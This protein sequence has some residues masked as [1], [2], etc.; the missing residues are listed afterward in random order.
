MSPCAR[1]FET[2]L[3]RKI[4]PNDVLV[5]HNAAGNPIENEVV[6]VDENEIQVA[7]LYNSGRGIRTVKTHKYDNLWTDI[8]PKELRTDKPIDKDV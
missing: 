2:A 4:E 5:S 1:E 3:D 7:T 6:G 8:V